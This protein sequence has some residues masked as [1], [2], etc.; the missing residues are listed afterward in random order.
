M[1]INNWIPRTFNSILLTSTLLAASAITAG[2]FG[3][4]GLHRDSDGSY[5]LY[6]N[7]AHDPDVVVIG[8]ELEGM[9]LAQKAKQEGLNVLILEP[10]SSLGGQLLQGEML[11]L[12]G[13]Y[14]DQGNSLVQGGMKELF[15]QYEAGA[16]RNKPQ[17]A[18]YFHHL[19]D[20]IP[21]EKK[22][23]LKN[24]YSDGGQVV[25]IQY[26][27]RFGK[28]RTVYPHYVVD[29][30]DDAA[31]IR[32]LNLE[33]LQGLE[34]LYGAREK[35]YMSATYIMRFK[36]V[37]WHKFYSHFWKMDKVERAHKYGPETYVD[38][39]ISYGFPPVVSAYKL[40]NKE[41]LNL[42]GL[43]I[44]NQ[45]N[46]EI[47]I[48]ALQVYGVDP[49]R[50]ETIDRGMR[51][52]KEEM[53]SIR[54][55]LRKQ[56]I[57][58]E[59]LELNGDPNYLYIREYNHY[60]TEYV[61]QASD[62]M[63]GRMFWDNV[64]IGGYFLDIQGSRSNREGLAIGRPDKY[65]IP[66]RSYLLQGTSNVVTAGKLVG[67]TAVAYGSTRIQPNG[68]IAAESIGVLM[69]QMQGRS[70][71]TASKEELDRLHRY[72]EKKYHIKLQPRESNNKIAHLSEREK[73]QLNQGILTLLSGDTVAQHLPFIRMVVDGRELSFSGIKP[74]LIQG[75]PWV[76]LNQTF[77]MLGAQNVRY[78]AENKRITFTYAGRKETI[79]SPLVH[80]L[81]NFVM[82]DWETAVKALGYH[83]Q[84]S[85]AERVVT[86][87]KTHHSDYN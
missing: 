31:L 15:H 70:L 32:K 28:T 55:H 12:D 57:G 56:I 38:S 29:N 43:N 16:I 24:V 11:Y 64:S 25:S 18:Q 26:V 79:E 66:L 40:N 5:T 83:W 42:R 10:K 21:L 2:V 9:Y 41:W 82:V 54:D 46:G 13:T 81:N 73:T 34:A 71:G 17:F 76:P 20:R 67:S 7:F 60:P 19:I 36:G 72:M 8:T 53:A 37:D 75:I 69:A 52:A 22:V 27:N 4:Y 47:V 33:P 14:D 59:G 62:L 74:I 39:N 6:P 68:T 23:E 1:N 78:D 61:M 50:E 58:F 51:L 35:E 44:L 85:E 3:Y 49:S 86:A 80:V 63:S 77:E 45:G 84:W 48:N 65:G 30:S 87:Q